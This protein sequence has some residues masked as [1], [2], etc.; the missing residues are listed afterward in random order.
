MFHR[1]CRH[2]VER[3]QNSPLQCWL[4]GPRAACGLLQNQHW[5]GG[6]QLGRTLGGLRTV[7]R[8]AIGHYTYP[9]CTQRSVPT[10]FDHDCSNTHLNGGSFP[11]VFPLRKP[12]MRP[13]GSE[14]SWRWSC[15]RRRS[16]AWPRRQRVWTATTDRLPP[17][18]RKVRNLATSSL[19][20]PQTP[21]NTCACL[22]GRSGGQTR[23]Y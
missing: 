20:N 21:G 15:C 8:I 4:F 7:E 18:R 10:N 6:S 5:R 17:M 12:L 22:N 2:T 23:G 3:F 11:C 14:R 9:C 19:T 13:S 16:S 1:T